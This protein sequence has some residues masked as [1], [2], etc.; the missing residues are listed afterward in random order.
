MLETLREAIE[1][2]EIIPSSDE[3]AEVFAL[4]SCFEAKIS[5]AVADFDAAGL[6]ELDYATSIVAWLRT[7]G[8]MTGRDAGRTA[9]IAKRLGALPVTRK[10][11]T[12]G[13]LS[14]GQV[15]AIVAN[16]ARR[17]ASLFAS[18]EEALIPKLAPLSVADTAAAMQEWASKARDNDP[19]PPALPQ[20]S[21][22]LSSM[23]DGR[24]RLDG[25]FDAEGGSLLG[26]AL[27]LAETKDGEA[28][29]ARV[30]SQR[31]GD[32]L[33]DVCRFFLDHQ[34]DH[35]GGRHRPH[36]NVTTTVDDIEVK[37]GGHIVG[38]PALDSAT[39]SRLVC[40]S[41]LHRVL[42][43]GRSAI[44]DYGTSTRTVPAPLWNALVLR[45]THCRAPGCDR[46][47]QWCEGHHVIHV[48]HGGETNLAN[49]VL[50]CSRHHHVWHLPGWELKLLPNGELHLTAPDGRFFVTRPPPRPER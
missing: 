20:R 35:R 39:L 50:A 13:T 45:D 15:Q 12:D 30:P 1:D 6:W 10:A 23:L 8:H 21:L 43:T 18:H 38:G 4:R 40:D 26:I 27:R 11:W 33:V 31:R 5:A 3:L 14:S 17:H 34:Q 44:L 37:R 42:M 2:L 22:H 25:E 29:E 41:A 19:E 9:S 47:P 16:V 32:A 49:L 24:F 28:D 36:L 7:H 46:G 48:P